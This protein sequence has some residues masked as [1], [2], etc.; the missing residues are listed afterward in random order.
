[1]MSLRIF[2]K[3]SGRT[4]MRRDNGTLNEVIG[5]EKLGLLLLI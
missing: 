3:N 2:I 1:M 4:F 5:E